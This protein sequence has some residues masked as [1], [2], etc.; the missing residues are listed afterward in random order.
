MLDGFLRRLLSSGTQATI[1]AVTPYDIESQRRRFPEIQWFSDGEGRREE[2]LRAADVWLGLGSTPF[3]IESG[4]WMLD[5]LDRERELCGRLKKPMLF[6]GVGCG[7][8]DAVRDPRGRRVVE[9]AERIWVRDERSAEA[10]GSVAAPGV[11][12]QGADLAHIVLRATARPQPEPA[13]LGLML[14]LH[15]AGIV[16]I[17]AVEESIARRP[18]GTTRWL[19]QEARS[20]PCTERWN[21]AGLSEWA[22]GRVCCM[23]F[24]YAH[25]TIQ[26][27]LA[28]FGAPE[29]V[30]SSRYH[31]ALIAAWHGC[32]LGV[33]A[34]SDKFHGVVAD[35][36]VPSLP[37]IHAADQLEALAR[38]A[39]PVDRRRLEALRERAV[40]MCDAFFAWLRER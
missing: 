29:T 28:N 21:F 8:P 5:H 2:Q 13:L 37:G 38:D 3:Q 32:R 26:Q 4:P 31:G 35:L 19:V 16:D 23:P 40:A 15:A 33:I 30:V 20:F 14:G 7:S 9:A 27:F 6:L 17:L 25:D 11:V 18:P 36:E 39:V 22:Q 24:D 10:I 12:E 34:R 1:I